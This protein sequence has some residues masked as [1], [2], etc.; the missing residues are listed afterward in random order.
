MPLLVLIQSIETAT[1][2]KLRRF[3]LRA[4]RVKIY[5]S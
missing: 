4:Q 2:V 3:C 5:S 1:P